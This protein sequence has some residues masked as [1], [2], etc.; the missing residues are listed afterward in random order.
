MIGSTVSAISPTDDVHGH[1]TLVQ[2][3]T[4]ELLRKY[5]RPGP[6]YTSY[7]TAVEFNVSFDERAYRRTLSEAAD[8]A[9]EPLSLYV[10]LPFCAQRC[11]FCGCM[12]I[13]TRK[14][15]VAARYLGYLQREIAMLA[16]ALGRRRRVVQ[17]HWG[18][19]TPTYL[20]LAQMRALQEVMTRHF[21]IDP[22][23][24]VAV[25]IDPRVT[26]GEQIVLLRS[27]GFNRLS[28]GVQDFSPKVQAIVN[29]NQHESETREIFAYARAVGFRSI[30][31]DLIYGLPC[32]T[33]ETFDR[34]LESMVDMRPERIAVYSYAHVPWLHPHQKRIDPRDLPSRELKFECFGLAIEKFLSAGYV[35]IGMDHFALPG[36][37]LAI[38]RDHR[39]LHRNFMGYT[40]KG[41]PDMLGLGVSAI[42]DVR[43]AFAQNG[44]KLSSY[45]AALDEGR[46]PIE[47]GYVLDADDRLRRYVITQLMC[48]FYLDRRECEA[49]FG[50]AFDDYFAS[51][52]AELAAGPVADGFLELHPDRLEVLPRGRLFIRNIC[53]T[54]DR[55]LRHK[56]EQ[57]VFSRTI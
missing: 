31:I 7:P 56:T 36:D 18:G 34:T 44:K 5:D 38:A 35:Q 37:E 39:T 43:G 1:A 48:N 57:P 50:I 52:V 3:V 41:A 32:Q 24:E 9:G 19:G 47:R 8:A 46:F 45:Y 53:M 21:E 33:P 20:D 40:T 15:E 23:A 30:N 27:M 49:R 2:S 12:V 29:R 22:Q 10:H 11:A 17:Y 16:G 54:F 6:R 51:E 26:T 4:A 13:V 14:R 42:G 25:E 55:Y 28:M